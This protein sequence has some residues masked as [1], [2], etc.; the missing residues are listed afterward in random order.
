M[1]RTIQQ[2]ALAIIGA[3]TSDDFTQELV[4]KNPNDLVGKKLLTIYK[5]SHVAMGDCKHDDWEV[6]L[7]KAYRYFK[8]RKII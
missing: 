5:F 1:N 8:R 7:L 4:Y 6:E 3:L 2:K